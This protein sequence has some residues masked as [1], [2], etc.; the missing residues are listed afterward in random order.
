MRCRVRRLSAETRDGISSW[1]LAP[2][3]VARRHLDALANPLVG[4]ATADVSGHHV[5]DIGIAWLRIR[6]QKCARGRDLPRLAVAALGYFSSEPRFLKL[7]TFRVH[8]R[9]VHR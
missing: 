8:L 1:L 6:F 7:H 3:K 9:T 4:T 2:S 5:V